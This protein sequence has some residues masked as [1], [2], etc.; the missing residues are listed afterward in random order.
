MKKYLIILS[1]L[2]SFNV[3]TVIAE[4]DSMCNL[5]HKEVIS[6]VG[7]IKGNVTKLTKIERDKLFGE[8]KLDTEQCISECKGKKLRYCNY[9]AKWVEKN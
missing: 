6:K 4:E 1:T 3:I 7:I 5:Y 2:L 8:L 9:I